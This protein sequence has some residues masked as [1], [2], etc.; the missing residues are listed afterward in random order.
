MTRV[1]QFN[2]KKQQSIEDYIHQINKS[3]AFNAGRLGT[4]AKIYEAMVKDKETKIFLG[5]SGAL[6]PAG[7]RDLV[8]TCLNNKFVDVLVTTGANLTH[9]LLESFDLHHQQINHYKSDAELEE[10]GINRIYDVYVTT[11]NFQALETKLLQLF[12]QMFQKKTVAEISTND[13]LHQL[14][15]KLNRDDSII[16]TAA[17]NDIPIYC[18]AITDSVLGLH[19]MNYFREHKIKLDPLE[20]L[21]DSINVAWDAKKTGALVL[22][23]GVPKNYIF[24][25]M[26]FSGKELDYA[27]QITMDRPEHGGLSGATLEEAVSWG[28]VSESGKSVVVISDVTVAFPLLVSYLLSSI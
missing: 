12:S 16:T 18:P 15:Q 2:A 10:E 27:I 4:A 8:V 21:Y 14:G 11:E 3:G 13:F 9:D 19:I 24:Q 22:G 1:H 25:S 5:L 6:V 7:M 23:G 20:E 17:K 26:L 28:K